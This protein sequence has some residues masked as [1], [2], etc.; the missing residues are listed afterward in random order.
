MF[1]LGWVFVWFF[2][3]YESIDI[4]AIFCKIWA[5]EQ[6]EEVMLL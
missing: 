4:C 1:V 2:L 6:Q 3:K 5:R